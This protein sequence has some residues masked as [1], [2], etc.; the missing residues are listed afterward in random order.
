MLDRPMASERPEITTGKGNKRRSTL[1]DDLKELRN[2][3]FHYGHDRAGDAALRAAMEALTGQP[4]GYVIRERTMRALY[5]D[6]VGTTLA[7]PFDPEFANDMHQRIVTLIQPTALFVQ[8]VEA[9]WLYA[10]RDDVTVSIPGR[11]R[12]SLRDFIGR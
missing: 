9:A 4:T 7:H 12:Q 2:R 11:A 3:F 8:Q 6:E 1:R 10:H 5:A